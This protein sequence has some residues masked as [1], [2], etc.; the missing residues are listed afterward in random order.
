MVSSVVMSRSFI[1]INVAIFTVQVNAVI[2]NMIHTRALNCNLYTNIENQRTYFVKNIFLF[3]T[4]DHQHV[5][6]E[7]TTNCFRLRPTSIPHPVYVYVTGHLPCSL[8][9]YCSRLHL[10]VPTS[11]LNKMAACSPKRMEPNDNI[12]W[13]YDSE[14]HN[15]NTDS[16]VAGIASVLCM[17][18][19]IRR[20]DGRSSGGA[21]QEVT[22]L[23]A[24]QYYNKTSFP[25]STASYFCSSS[26]NTL[27]C[28]LRVSFFR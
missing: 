7:L 6:V 18:Y 21:F 19:G 13:H 11:P 5:A 23:R 12:T 10:N 3:H 2:F 27:A 9:T 26:C 8:R 1:G 20:V 15:P 22:W 16:G 25:D 4:A 17:L 28:W 24:M 14:D